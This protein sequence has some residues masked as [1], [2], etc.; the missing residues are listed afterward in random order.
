MNKYDYKYE[1]YVHWRDRPPGFWSQN[2]NL[3]VNDLGG[4]PLNS[5]SYVRDYSDINIV[6]IVIS[7][8]LA[9]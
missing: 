2:E 6:L 1:L 8:Y 5:D 9:D 7:P 3:Q 4:H